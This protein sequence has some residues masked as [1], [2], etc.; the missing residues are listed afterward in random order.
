MRKLQKNLRLRFTKEER[1]DPHLKK[2]IYKADIAA[3]K[4][5]KAQKKITK[6][7]IVKKERTTDSKTGKQVVRLHF[8]EVEKN[9]LPSK[10]EHA[11]K[12]VPVGALHANIHR[13]IRETEEDNV[14]VESAHKLEEVGERSVRIVSSANRSRKLRPYKRARVAEKKLEKANVNA[15]YQKYRRE[16]PTLHTNPMSRYQQKQALKKQYV[17]MRSEWMRKESS[18]AT[19]ATKT[20]VKATARIVSK[21]T[22]FVAANSK[23]ILVMGI[24]IV[25]IMVLL[26]FFSSVMM[27]FQ[28][29]SSYIATTT[30]PSKDADMLAAESAYAQ[31]EA[32]IQSELDYYEEEHQGYDEYHYELDTISHN[33]Y[34]LISILTV[35]HQEFIIADVQDTLELL[36]N[37]QYILME[38]VTIEV[39]YREET[40]TWVDEM[41]I[42][43]TE[44]FQV[45]YDYKICTI[46]LENRDLSH[47][48]V[49]IMN[50]EQLSFFAVYMK[51]LG[52]RPDLFPTEDY[53][54]AV[55]PGEYTDY[56]IPSDALDDATFAA[57]IREAEKYLGF[58]YVWGGASPSTSFDC[59]G[60]V[61][62]VIN[63]SGW[64]VGRRT[65]QGLL[66]ICTP[67]A[68]SN[69]KPG[70]LIFFKATY[71][72]PGASH[73]GIYVG[74]GMMIHCGDPISY[75]SI[76][77]TYWQE[78]F[79]CFGRLPGN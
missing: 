9:K 45:C 29:G 58:P 56:E 10:L 55:V 23:V 65:A 7:K 1:A 41:G 53:P 15:L 11:V 49:E 25:I 16:N 33:P 70:D 19:K 66:D 8:E 48:P 26:S 14:G 39:R 54:N 52:N 69:V 57:M 27:L 3:D 76:N 30:Y 61:S 34:V 6:K 38:E 59:S 31:M 32:N 37:L 18:Q 24:I 75:A 12:K 5:E 79:Y 13:Q 46:T 64:N 43:Q 78:Y 62:W 4:A 51:T 21:V 22:T 74:G 17:R 47:L 73:V 35:L 2:A 77:T 28:G 36:F 72:T 68:M 40:I 44:T 50:E 20:V 67:V 71:K 42:M 60:F 63:H